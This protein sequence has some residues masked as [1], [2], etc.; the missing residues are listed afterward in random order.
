MVLS[1]VEIGFTLRAAFY[2]VNFGQFWC[3][4]LCYVY[5]LVDVLRVYVWIRWPPYFFDRTWNFE[6]LLTTLPIPRDI[7]WWNRLV[8]AFLERIELFSVKPF[9]KHRNKVILFWPFWQINVIFWQRSAPSGSF[10]LAWFLL[11]MAVE[12]LKIL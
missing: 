2:Y 7:W 8:H 9:L 6:S 10:N 1:A 3:S 11:L 12:W 5:F 4:V